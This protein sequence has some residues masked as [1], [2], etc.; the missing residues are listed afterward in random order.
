VQDAQVSHGGKS[1]GALDQPNPNNAGGV[2]KDGV[3]MLDRIMTQEE[4]FKGRT[5]ERLINA[6]PEITAVLQNG[7]QRNAGH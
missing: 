7:D 4:R 2:D 1:I 5:R 3:I 6:E